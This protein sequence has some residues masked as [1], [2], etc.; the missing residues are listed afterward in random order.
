M[1]FQ[2]Y[3]DTIKAKTGLGQ[4]DL[5]RI[6]GEKGLAKHGDVM[7]WA[8]GELGLGHG[9]A[10]AISA[11]LLKPDV[12]TEA[13][14]E[15]LAKYFTA[16]KAHWRPVYDG[17]EAKVKGFGDDVAIGPAESYINFNRNGKKFAIFAAGVERVDVGIKLKG[18]D[19]GERLEAAGS[20]NQM[21]THRVRVSDSA[22][23]DAELL[24]WL[25]AAYD[26]VS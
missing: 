12:F 17:L 21:V 25:R 5:R 10:Q 4:D 26:A 6:A 8:K 23:I 13:A 20:W 1:T 7:A 16:K 9:H 22:Q 11:L 2:A 24:A 19:P 14:D 3:F 15:K 18:Y